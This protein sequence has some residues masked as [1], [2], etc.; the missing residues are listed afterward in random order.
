MTEP[1]GPEWVR[2]RVRG[3][4]W[5]LRAASA[6]PRYHRSEC[7]LE[8]PAELSDTSGAEPATWCD[9]CRREAIRCGR[10]YNASEVADGRE[11]PETAA[12]QTS[13]PTAAPERS[14]QES[15]F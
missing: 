11:Q 8:W 15:L 5:H 4:I 7:G 14:D 6:W 10:R 3:A 9:E 13:T 2:L 1:S 12:E